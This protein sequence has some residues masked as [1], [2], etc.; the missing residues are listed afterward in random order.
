MGLGFRL[1]GGHVCIKERLVVR[2]LHLDIATGSSGI[3]GGSDF[4]QHPAHRSPAPYSENHERDF[5]ALKVLLI[6]DAFIRGQHDIKTCLLGGAEQIAVL[7]RGPATLPRF[8]DRVA[9]K[10]TCKAARSIV[11]EEDQHRLEAGIFV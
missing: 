6:P 8:R 11:I 9:N 10:G 1:C 5:T 7:Q 4:S 3:H 2:D